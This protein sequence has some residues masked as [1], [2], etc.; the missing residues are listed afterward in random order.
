MNEL[1]EYAIA[2]CPRFLVF[3]CLLIVVRCYV[4]Q[5]LACGFLQYLWKKF[6]SPT[7]QPIFRQA[8]IAYMGSLMSRATFVSVGTVREHLSEMTS[9]ALAYIVRTAETC[10]LADVTHHGP[11]YTVC[12]SVFY[13]FA[14]RHKQLLADSQG[15]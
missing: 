2:L 15:E 4:F 10:T 5:K 6:S 14:F 12:Q 8:A 7:S 13:V 9:W 11:F 3:D 1:F